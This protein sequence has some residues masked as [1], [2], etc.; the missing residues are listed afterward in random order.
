M[1]EKE[2]G[3]LG[4]NSNEREVYL[5]LLRAGKASPARI[6]KETSINRTTVY[7]IS[8]K[9]ISLGLVGEDLSAKVGYL[10][11]EQPSAIEQIFSKEETLL[12]E[13]KEVAKSI[14]A[15]LAA[16][17][18]AKSYSVPRIKFIE[19][20]NLDDYLRKEYSNW[21]QSG[22]S[23][24]NTWWGYIDS[25]FTKQYKEWIDWTWIHGPKDQKV[26]FLT[27][28]HEA[29][30]ELPAKYPERRRKILK[31]NVFDSSLFVIG[32][33][34]LMA[35]ARERPHYLVEIHDAVFARNQRQLFKMLWGII[36]SK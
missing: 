3:R 12:A 10:Y 30:D 24:D 21:S 16:L 7:S 17:P 11:A 26:R 22:S 31:E 35:Q 18:S 19:E 5:A 23:I 8:R 4:L 27:N 34:V 13:R 1:L 29:E 28:E 36:D 32:D 6:A 9:L 33:F 15:Q 25:S 2:F 20:E 14:A